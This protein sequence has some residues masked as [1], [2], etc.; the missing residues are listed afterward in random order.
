MAKGLDTSTTALTPEGR[1]RLLAELEELRTTGRARAADQVRSA[2]EEARDWADGAVLAEAHEEQARIEARIVEL[3]WLLSTATVTGAPSADGRAGIGSTVTVRAEDGE[4]DAYTLVGSAEAL[5]RAGRI[6]IS[7]PV[8]Q[9]LFGARAGDEVY[10][11]T[12]DGRQLLRVMAV[13]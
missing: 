13:E 8:G 3:E 6:S 12:P 4:V 1:A 2:R 7:S 9:A 5:P 11:D 10:V